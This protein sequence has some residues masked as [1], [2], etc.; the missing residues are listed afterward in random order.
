MEDSID[1]FFRTQKVRFT[2]AKKK[3]KKQILKMKKKKKKD[4]VLELRFFQILEPKRVI[5]PSSSGQMEER[6]WDFKLRRHPENTKHLQL[7][8][9]LASIYQLSWIKSKHR[10]YHFYFQ[11]IMHPG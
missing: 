3:K 11:N 4:A 6:G 7:P 10:K 9:T 5:A 1:T 2:F 8:K